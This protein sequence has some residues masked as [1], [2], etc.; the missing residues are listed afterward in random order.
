MRTG[1]H[2]CGA[3]DNAATQIL[4]TIL[5]TALPAGNSVIRP[6]GQPRTVRRRRREQR[7]KLIPAPAVTFAELGV[8]A[9]LV[10]ALGE[11]GITVPFPVQAATLPDALAGVDI[12]G[13]AQTG[14]GKTLGFCIPLVARL[15]GGYTMACRPRGLVLVPTREL[16]TQVQAVLSPLAGAMGLSVTAIFGGTPQNPQVAALRNRADLVVACPGR[17]A[18]LIGQD[19]CHLGDVEVTVLDEADHMADLGFLPAVR[20]L[21]EAT[22]PEGQR[23]LFSATL[24]SAVD[25]LARR[26]LTRPAQHSVDDA[27]RRPRSSIICSPSRRPTGWRSSRPWP[28]VTTAC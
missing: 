15:A 13:R 25:V 24:D 18:D 7:P 4:E 28:A 9:P 14:S 1:F 23:L 22:P 17:L 10:A 6:V 26:F 11:D 8:P 27:S 5:L 20:R 12:L 16:A 3:F 21:L 2:G 19:H